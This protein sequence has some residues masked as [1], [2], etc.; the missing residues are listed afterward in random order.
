MKKFIIMIIGIF[1][2]TGCNYRELNDLAIVSGISIDRV[3]DEYEILVQVVNPTKN[4]EVSSSDEPEFITYTSHAKTL[5]EAFRNVIWESPRKIYG[6]QMQILLISERLAKEDLKNILDF[7]FRDPEIRMEFYVAIE[8][9]NGNEALKTLTALD[10]LSSSNIKSS[11]EADSA[12][13][14]TSYLVTYEDFMNMYLD[15]NLEI[16]LPSIEVVGN[17]EEGENENNLKNTSDYSSVIIENLAV[18]KDNTLEGY[19]S[20]D[21]SIAY[22]FITGNISSTLVS[23]ECE[24]KKYLVSEIIDTKTEVEADVKKKK[25]S[26]KITGDASINECTCDYDLAKEKVIKDIN[27]KINKKIEKMIDDAIEE[28]KEEY[29][30]DIYGFR[31]MFYKSDYKEFVKIKDNWYEDIFPEL[32][33]EV[34]SDIG[35]I[36][37]G[38]LLGGIYD[39]QES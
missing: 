20:R 1:L 26:I 11:L 19:L 15:D 3:D 2:L 14:G 29:N 39:K 34:K 23:Y 16:V 33:I 6:S 38:K 27:E 31:D 12:Y 10:N 32:E 22:N 5:Q 7:F 13:L 8:K 25:I 35:L 9:N 21:D 28:V 4:Q 37:K 18:F 24:D 36:E 17:Y 30:S